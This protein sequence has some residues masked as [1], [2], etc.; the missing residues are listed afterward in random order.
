MCVC[1]REREREKG[2]LAYAHVFTTRATVGY[3]SALS[4]P[5]YRRKDK[6]RKRNRRDRDRN[7]RKRG[8][9]QQRCQAKRDQRRECKFSQPIPLFLF[10]H[11]RSGGRHSFSSLYNCLLDVVNERLNR[12][13]CFFLFCEVTWM[14]EWHALFLLLCNGW[15]KLVVSLLLKFYGNVQGGRARAEAQVRV[16]PG[17]TARGQASVL[18]PIPV[19]KPAET[20]VDKPPG[21][22]Q[23][24]DPG[25]GPK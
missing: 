9:Q 7:H 20:S 3:V 24:Q 25:T 14:P 16:K 10:G 12:A 5:V 15:S 18:A 11:P 19:H 22:I 13:C 8:I 2:E 21:D 23:A 17:R 1:E 4:S 6:G